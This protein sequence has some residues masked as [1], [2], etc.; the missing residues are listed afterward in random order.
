MDG[1]DAVLRCSGA[2]AL[3]SLWCAAY[4]PSEDG[5]VETELEVFYLLDETLDDPCLFVRH[6]T[7]LHLE[8][9]DFSY[10]ASQACV[11]FLALLNAKR[12]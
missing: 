4:H 11:L 2:L 1:L 8:N 12:T 3:A 6:S 7:T 10:S 9:S 5:R